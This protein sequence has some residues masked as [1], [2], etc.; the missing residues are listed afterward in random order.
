MW[1]LI[2]VTIF[3]NYIWSSNAQ[4]QTN[5]NVAFPRHNNCAI[6]WWHNWDLN[7]REQKTWPIG[8]DVGSI[9]DPYSWQGPKHGTQSYNLEVKIQSSIEKTRKTFPHNQYRDNVG[10][11]HERR[12]HIFRIFWHPLPH[13]GSFS[14]LYASKSKYNLTQLQTTDVFFE[15]LDRPKDLESF[16]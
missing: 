3:F 11:I 10:T 14:I 2:L 4:T 12:R 15:L 6:H 13:V 8:K 9:V 16:L 1:P 5:A 7:H